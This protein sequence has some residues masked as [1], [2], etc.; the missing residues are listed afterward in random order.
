MCVRLFFTNVLTYETY[1]QKTIPNHRN[2]LKEI[3]K[4]FHEYANVRDNREKA[5]K[6][7][8]KSILPATFVKIRTSICEIAECTFLR[9]YIDTIPT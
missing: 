3:T 4:M 1:A 2:G 9:R 8:F 5:Y 7:E 6:P